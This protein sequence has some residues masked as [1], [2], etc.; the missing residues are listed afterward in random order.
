MLSPGGTRGVQLILFPFIG[1]GNVYWTFHFR[2]GNPPFQNIENVLYLLGVCN[3]DT[4][5]GPIVFTY[6][7]FC[8]RKRILDFQILGL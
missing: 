5:G 2:G 1:V 4:E 3:A 6:V 7:L 8:I